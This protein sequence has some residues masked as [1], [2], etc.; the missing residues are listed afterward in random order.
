[1]NTYK[2]AH[3]YTCSNMHHH[4]FVHTHTHIYI[5]IYIQGAFKKKKNITKYF[6]CSNKLPLLIK[7]K[8]WISFSSSIKRASML[9]QQ[10]M[11]SHVFLSGWDLQ[12]FGRPLYIYIYIYIYLTKCISIETIWQILASLCKWTHT[13]THTHTYIYIYIY[14]YWNLADNLEKL[15]LDSNLRKKHSKTYF[16]FYFHFY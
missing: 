10:K 13:H 12:I 1:M 2:H 14:I 8:V 3:S 11:F 16:H 15:S 5:Y 4:K 7:L 6:C 9:T